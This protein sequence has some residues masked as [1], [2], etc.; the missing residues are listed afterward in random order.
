MYVRRRLWGVV[1]GRGGSP[2][3][4]RFSVASWGRLA[5]DRRHA[6]AADPAAPHVLHNEV[7]RSGRVARPAQAVQ[8][9]D[10][11]LG[12]VGAHL[13]NP[14]VWVCADHLVIA[15]FHCRFPLNGGRGECG[16]SRTFD[17]THRTGG[18]A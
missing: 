8:V 17:A 9:V 4:V 5:H 12:E 6:L 14:D 15:T 7:V 13:D 10:E 1:L 3:A 18:D 11:R 2:S 16:Q